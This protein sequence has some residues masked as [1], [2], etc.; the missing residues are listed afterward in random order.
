LPFYI[1]DNSIDEV[2]VSLVELRAETF[3]VGQITLKIVSCKV[4]KHEKACFNNQH[5]FI[6]VTF[7]I[8]DFLAPEVVS[9]LQGVQKLMNS[10]V[11]S[12]KVMNVVFKRIDFDI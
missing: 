2:H 5:T 6:P 12:P 3:I 9:L 4:A 8:F 1:V 7:D 11:M 10:N